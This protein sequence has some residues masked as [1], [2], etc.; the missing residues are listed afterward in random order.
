M[1][2]FICFFPDLSCIWLGCSTYCCCAFKVC[3]IEKIK[4]CNNVFQPKYC[5]CVLQRWSCIM[6]GLMHHGFRLR[7]YVTA[8]SCWYEQL[9]FKWESS[10]RC[11]LSKADQKRGK[12]QRPKVNDAQLRVPAF[13]LLL[14]GDEM[15][16][17]GGRAN[18]QT[19]QRSPCGRRGAARVIPALQTRLDLETAFSSGGG[20]KSPG[21][22][23]G[24]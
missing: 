7:C 3:F 20:P 9:Q 22:W 4:G 10:A 23:T 5:I 6:M 19:A 8:M 13:A 14:P 15:L 24:K 18:G 16:H 17:S 1:H 12:G 21:N 2:T 11:C